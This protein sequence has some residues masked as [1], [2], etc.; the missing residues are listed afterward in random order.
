MTTKV[1]RDVIEDFVVSSNPNLGAVNVRNNGSD[2]EVQFNPALSIPS[3]AL[4][5]KVAVERAEIWFTFP[6]ISE[7]L[8]NNKIYITEGANPQIELTIPTGLYSLEQLNESLQTL[9]LNAGITS[10]P[11]PPFEIEGNDATQKVEITINYTNI[12]LEF[13]SDSP[14]DLL[15]FPVG[16]IGPPAI[17]PEVFFAPSVAQFNSVNNVQIHSN[18]VNNGIPL[19]NKFSGILANVQ[20]NVPAGSQI[21]YA[22]FRPLF[23]SAENLKS[24]SRTNVR[25]YITDENG[26]FLDTNAEY[27]SATIR[28]MYKLPMMV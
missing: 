26:N 15:G 11:D 20:I 2:F 17:A 21:L 8:G 1:L 16:V 4:D 25:F 22:P 19:N 9:A 28:L 27:W 3:S 5:L 18:L 10:S 7:T 14:T 13:K 24:S 12:S 6:N 23:C